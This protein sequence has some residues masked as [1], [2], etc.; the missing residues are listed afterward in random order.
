MAGHVLDDAVVVDGLVSGEEPLQRDADCGEDG[1]S[2]G[3][4][5]KWIEDEWE[6]DIVVGNGFLIRA[7]LFDGVERHGD[8]VDQVPGG[9]HG[10]ELIEEGRPNLWP[11]QKKYC[12]NISQS[13]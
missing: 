12:S 11:S 8:D 4:V 3:D 5:V 10:Q 9:K 2:H 13:P 6:H 7:E 1:S